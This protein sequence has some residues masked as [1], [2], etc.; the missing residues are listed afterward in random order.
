MSGIVCRVKAH[1]LH[2]LL[3]T[4][5]QPPRLRLLPEDAAV[6]IEQLQC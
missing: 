4:C 3:H 5:A 1:H 6:A 2:L